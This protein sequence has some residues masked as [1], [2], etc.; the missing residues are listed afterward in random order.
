MQRK[1]FSLFLIVGTFFVLPTQAQETACN[2][3]LTQVTSL[4]AE[5][6][7][8]FE[9][10]DTAGAVG[11]MADAR[12]DLAL[13]EAQCLNYAPDTA[14]DKRTNPVPLGERLK[15]DLSEDGSASIQIVNYIDNANEFAEFFEVAETERLIGIEISYMCESELDA[16]CSVGPFDSFSVVGSQGISYDTKKSNT[17]PNSEPLSLYGGGQG[18]YSMAFLVD[19]DDSDFVLV[20]HPGFGIEPVFFSLQ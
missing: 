20:L 8:S 1:I 19:A 18:N 2:P 12:D 6:Q 17:L 11:L 15:F 14:G 7:A 5:A 16:T 4:L 3:D 9:S 10:G 13:Q